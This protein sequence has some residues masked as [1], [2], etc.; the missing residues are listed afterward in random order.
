M[1]RSPAGGAA[2][3]GSLDRNAAFLDLLRTVSIAANEA[4]DLETPLRTTLDA[5]CRLTGWPVG[6]IYMRASEAPFDLV[7]S[8]IWHL[9]EADRFRVFREVTER[10][11]LA[12]GSGLPG[13]VLASGKPQWFPDVTQHPNFPRARLAGDIGVRAGFGMPI[14]VGSEIPAVL[15]FFT[16]V[17]LPP[18]EEFLGVMDL[19]GMLLGRV[20]ERMR[21]EDA[22]RNLATGVAAVKGN[23]F[24]LSLANHLV[25]TLQADFGLIGMLQ[26]EEGKEVRTLAA[27]GA[28]GILDRFQYRLEG[29]PCEKVIHRTT[30]C[31]YPRDVQRLFPRDEMLVRM[32][33]EAYC[34]SPL[35]SSSGKVIGLMVAAYRRPLTNPTMAESLLKVFAVRA[36]TELERQRAQRSLEKLALFPRADPN[37]VLEFASD[38]TLTYYNSAAERL[39]RSLDKKDPKD[40]L[41]ADTP[42]LVRKCL[43][44]G[45]NGIVMETTGGDRT[46]SWA[47][48]PVANRGLVLAYAVEISFLLTLE[49]EMRRM[50]LLD[51][52]RGRP[53]RPRR[54][55]PEAAGEDE[56][57]VH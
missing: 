23:A 2:E 57:P 34:G 10:T 53:P 17:A 30:S 1:S 24:F 44:T 48:I 29:T 43:D 21:A 32:G 25:R 37:P 47:F 33:V 18:D 19:V 22:L 7:P 26:G 46:V 15:E 16:D 5:V 56:A 52:P 13:T 14:R 38:G 28:D 40:I 41:P 35:R 11:R 9:D 3:S 27:I 42:G 8:G 39:A 54:A 55:R 36:A 49:E 4:N 6:H 45:L 31:I 12:P 51:P 50:H 20:I